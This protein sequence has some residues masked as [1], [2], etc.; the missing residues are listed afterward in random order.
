MVEGFKKGRGAS[1]GQVYQ[2]SAGQKHSPTG[3]DTT[4]FAEEGSFLQGIKECG[5][6]FL[7]SQVIW[8]EHPT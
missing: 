2:S 8:E 7:G 3:G 6:F 5:L 1:Q 4:A